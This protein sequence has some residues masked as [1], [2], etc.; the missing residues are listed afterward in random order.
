MSASAHATRST[1][2]CAACPTLT[3]LRCFPGRLLVLVRMM[4]GPRMDVHVTS[5][6]A[7]GRDGRIRWQSDQAGLSPSGSG[8][9]PERACHAVGVGAG[10]AWLHGLLHQQAAQAL[11]QRGA[12]DEDLRRAP[13]PSPPAPRL[14]PCVGCRSTTG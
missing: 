10:V 12:A 11:L 8:A 14:S 6:I 7:F 2:T 9:L 1:C 13:L 5:T 4:F 3:P